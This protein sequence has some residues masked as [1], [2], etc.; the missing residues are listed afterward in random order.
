[1]GL[2]SRKSRSPCPS[3]AIGNSVDRKGDPE[4]KKQSPLV[5]ITGGK[6]S[7]GVGGTIG[8]AYMLKSLSES[9]R[10]CNSCKLLSRS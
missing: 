9:L 6:A 3:A 2:A 8:L 5:A 10:L 4:V 7:G 1:M